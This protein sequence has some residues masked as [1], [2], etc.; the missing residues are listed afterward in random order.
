MCGHTKGKGGGQS[1]FSDI[2]SQS[3]ERKGAFLPA[4]T[5]INK[6]S[7]RTLF[8]VSGDLGGG[9]GGG[10][11]GSLGPCVTRFEVAIERAATNNSHYNRHLELQSNNDYLK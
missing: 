1:G 8:P 11:G 3:L 7:P 4:A 6:P 2:T 5:V 10:G 9:G